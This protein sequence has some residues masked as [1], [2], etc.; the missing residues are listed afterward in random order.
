MVLASITLTLAL[1]LIFGGLRALHAQAF[2]LIQSCRLAERACVGG[3]VFTVAHGSYWLNEWMVEY[4]S[5]WWILR[6]GQARPVHRSCLV[7]GTHTLI[8]A[9]EGA[10]FRHARLISS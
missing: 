10:F 2:E 6:M 7:P 4:G 5:V 9:Q 8:K 1:I 3:I